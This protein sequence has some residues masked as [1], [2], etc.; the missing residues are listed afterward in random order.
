MPLYHRSMS[1]AHAVRIDAKFATPEDVAD[2]LGVSRVRAKRL[3]R[4]VT[5]ADD[6]A[7]SSVSHDKTQNHSLK[8]GDGARR[9][10][11]ARATA[12]KRPR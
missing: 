8:G 9:K 4:L 5:L 11:R 7:N 2:T 6:P 10:R 1:H 12:S 3:A